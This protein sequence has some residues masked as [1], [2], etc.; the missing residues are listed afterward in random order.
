MDR[1]PWLEL[2]DIEFPPIEEA[3]G[4]PNGLLAAGGDLSP[5]RLIKAYQSGIFPWYEEGQ[6]ILWWSP[7]PRIVI[8]PQDVHISKSLHKTLR[9]GR[10]TVTADTAFS[11]VINY[12]AEPRPEQKGTWITDEMANAY[13]QL[14][15]LGYAHSIETWREGRLCGGLYGIALGGLFFGE[16]MFSKENDASKVAFATLATRLSNWGFQLI[17]CQVETPHL[18]SLGAREISREEFKKI[19]Q[20]YGTP[21]DLEGTSGSWRDRW[22][23]DS[24]NEAD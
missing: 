16:S 14:H 6:P 11:Q 9:Q 22:H 21:T 15:E 10:F 19:L 4:E 7:D 23:Q 2:D 12:C 24:Q 1:I 5:A 18:K 20:Q 17:D 13:L 8:R 3:W